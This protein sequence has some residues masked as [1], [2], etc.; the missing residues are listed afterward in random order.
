M[1]IILLLFAALL[2]FGILIQEAFRIPPPKEVPEQL[3]AQ[4]V[5]NF[6]HPMPPLTYR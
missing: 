2:F 4:Q 3:S 6:G 1:K 5:S